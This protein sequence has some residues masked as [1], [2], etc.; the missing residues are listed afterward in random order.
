MTDLI[1][2]GSLA[3]TFPK[4]FD[5]LKAAQDI[6][7]GI[8]SFDDLEDTFLRGRGLSPNT[9]RSYLTST[10]L[11]YAFTDGLHPFQVTPSHIERWHEHLLK[12]SGRETAVVRMR[13]LKRFFDGVE[14]QVP[15]FES[16]FKII[17]KNL[18]HKLFKSG[19]GNRKLKALSKDEARALLSW[20]RDVDTHQGR[21]NYAA[22][23]M[24][25][26]SGLRASEL[27]QLTWGNLEFF[28]G[29]WTATF[30]GKGDKS[31]EQELIGEA[32]DSCREY[33]RKQFKRDP[34][35]EDH[36]FWTVP[37]YH[38]DKL[39]PMEYAVLYRRIKDIGLAARESGIIKREL[40]FTPHLFR[41]SYCTLLYKSGMKVKAIQNKSRHASVDTLMRHYIK[42]DDA[43]APY[44]RAAL[45]GVA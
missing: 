33:F 12:T 3:A 17:S 23:H 13:G 25:V 8:H 10:R 22:V 34:R 31:A 4:L 45:A 2:S 41:R 39:R 28:E 20:L 1:L 36:L 24:L 5:T 9:Y 27:L 7:D 16:P 14:V 26:T 43:A 11:F 44:L 29:A 32:V 37:G 6:L 15:F 21:C 35:P 19:K 18:H 40:V 42:D 30:T 38:G